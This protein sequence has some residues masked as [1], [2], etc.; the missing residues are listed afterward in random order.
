MSKRIMIA[1]TGA[2]PD[3]MASAYRIHCYARGLAESGTPVK[4][5]STESHKLYPGK[6]F[7]YSGS[8]Q[9]IPFTIL[10]NKKVSLGGFKETLWGELKSYALLFYCFCKMRNYDIVWLYNMGLLPRLLLLPVLHLFGKK[11]VLELNEFPYSTGG[12]KFTRIR[13]VNKLMK[14]CTL[15]LVYR[16]LDGIIAISE[17][18][19]KVIEKNAPKVPMI[20]IPILVIPPQDDALPKEDRIPHGN[21]YIFHAGSLSKQK[22]GIVKVVMAYAR[23]AKKLQSENIKL[24]L[25]LTNKKTNKD[26]LD[27]IEAVLNE[28]GIIDNLVVTGFLGDKQLHAYLRHSSALIINKPA[29]IQNLYNFPTKLGDYLL[30]GTPVIVASKGIE[31]NKFVKNGENGIVVLPDDVD[32]MSDALYTL[33]T[34]EEKRN[35]LGAKGRSTAIEYFDYKTNAGIIQEFL[36]K[37]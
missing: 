34:D 14:W 18:L 24:D 5:V 2:Y 13:A 10:W 37:V 20:K 17:N 9:D 12:N 7:L 36:N 28:N 15:R 23:T 35:T 32:A 8:H 19:V 1:T 27:N 6:R 21:P 30:S 16:Q 29:T 26:V 11:V 22:D 3:G 25:V 4:V 33:C 31:L